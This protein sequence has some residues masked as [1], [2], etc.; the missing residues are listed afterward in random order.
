MQR[1]ARTMSYFG[2][3]VLRDLKW[4]ALGKL[5]LNNIIKSVKKVIMKM[6]LS[7][8]NVDKLRMLDGL[9]GELESQKTMSFTGTQQKCRACE[10]TVY[11][12]ELLS[13]DGVPFH[14]S[15]FKC[16]HCKST[17]QVSFFILFSPLFVYEYE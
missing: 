12:M 5:L 4:K 2:F 14:K 9:M 17:L 6:M 1:M 15:C 8:V 16:F 13:A 7:I 3:V 11:P 10:K